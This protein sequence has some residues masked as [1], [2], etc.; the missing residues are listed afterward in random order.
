MNLEKYRK[1]PISYYPIR[2]FYRYNDYGSLEVLNP[3]KGWMYSDGPTSIY[4]R[5]FYTIIRILENKGI[6][7]EKAATSAYRIAENN[8]NKI[9]KTYPNYVRRLNYEINR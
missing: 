3:Q 6:P 7:I 5:T 8:Y 2:S 1:E 9:K 4:W